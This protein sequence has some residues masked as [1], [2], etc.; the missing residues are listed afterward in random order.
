VTRHLPALSL[1]AALA[2]GCAAPVP[3]VSRGETLATGD[4]LFDDFFN[5]VRD[6][7]TEALAAQADELASHAGLIKALGLEPKTSPSSAVGESGLR[8]RRLQDKGVLLH[9]EIAPDAKLMMV[10]AKYD[11][12]AEGEA[13][14]KAMEEAAKTSLDMRRR[15]VSV[16]LRAAEL[17]R[18]RVTLRTQASATFRDAPQSKRD[19][20]TFELDA[21]QPVLTDAGERASNAAGS[22]ARF[23]VELAQAVETGAGSAV[24]D[25]KLAKGAKKPPAAPVA[26]APPPPVVVAAAAPPKA[27]P[28]PAKPAAPRA[29]PAPAPAKPAAAPAKKKPKGGGDDFEP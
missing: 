23:V 12:G 29:A 2:L 18:R 21:A 17:E 20:I 25:T 11:P 27:A 8:A 14:F 5:A 6:V 16:A 3:R 9:L 22:A 4:T 7:R 24:V 26:A 28:A 19:E 15:L 13:L 10:R 1:L